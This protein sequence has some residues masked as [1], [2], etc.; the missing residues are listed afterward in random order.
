MCSVRSADFIYCVTDKLLS[1]TK[2]YLL[3]L[4]GQKKKKNFEE[5][6]PFQIIFN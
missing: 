3:L 4:V 6:N 5:K 2:K 1:D